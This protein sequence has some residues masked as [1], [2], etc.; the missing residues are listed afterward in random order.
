MSMSTYINARMTMIADTAQCVERI[1]SHWTTEM[2]RATAVDM[3][4]IGT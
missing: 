1:H 2:D 4:M 3:D